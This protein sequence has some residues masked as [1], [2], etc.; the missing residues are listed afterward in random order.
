MKNLKNVTVSV[1]RPMGGILNGQDEY[2]RIEIV[3]HDSR[4]K[5]IQ[6]DM[7]LSEFAKL[8]TGRSEVPAGRAMFNDSGAIGKKRVYEKRRVYISDDEIAAAGGSWPTSNLEQWLRDTQ[9]EEGWLVDPYLGSQSS[10]ARDPEIGGGAW[11]NYG[12]YKYVDILE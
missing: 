7:E 8:I 1:G 11:L 12:V 6:L 3:D 2:I 4:M 9:Q 10:Q 5:V